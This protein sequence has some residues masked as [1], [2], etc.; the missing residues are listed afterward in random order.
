MKIFVLVLV[1][2]PRDYWWL[3]GGWMFTQQLLRL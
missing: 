2:G 3:S 1:L